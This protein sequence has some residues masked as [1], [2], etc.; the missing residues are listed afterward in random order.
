MTDQS[1]VVIVDGRKYDSDIKTD[2]DRRLADANA[3]LFRKLQVILHPAPRM[4]DRLMHRL[5]VTVADHI[6][7]AR[8]EGI[9]YPDLVVV[10]LDQVRAV[11]LWRADLDRK[12]IERQLL[13]LVAEHPD[14]TADEIAR[15]VRA[16]FPGYRPTSL[17][18]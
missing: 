8:Q 14:I 9:D 17:V 16:S 2:A 18:A 1:G 15:A 5:K 13:N 6:I 4:T 3:S 11:K 10:W 7:R 12:D